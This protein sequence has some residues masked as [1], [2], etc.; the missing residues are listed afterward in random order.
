MTTVDIKG[1][2]K[3]TLLH[4][5]WERSTPA[6]FFKFSYL[7]PPPFDLAKAKSQLQN[8]YADYVCGRIIKADIYNKD[9]VDP[10]SYDR[11]NGIGAFAEV[12]ANLRAV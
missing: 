4:A 7:P 9:V 6:S 5:L 12:V 3:D 2:D 10:W 1:L 11:D 8:G